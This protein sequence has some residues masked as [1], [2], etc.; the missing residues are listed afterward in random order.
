[1]KVSLLLPL[2]AALAHATV[3]PRVVKTPLERGT[4]LWA[5]LQD[6]KYPPFDL[7]I[8]EQLFEENYQVES[9]GEQETKLAS[10]L[11]LGGVVYKPPSDD[12]V[13]SIFT[14]VIQSNPPK[15]TE[16]HFVQQFVIEK[17]LIVVKDIDQ[18]R[19]K[20]PNTCRPLQ[21]DQITFR[22]YDRLAR[23]KGSPLSKLKWVAQ[24]HII[25]P[26]TLQ[27][28]KEVHREPGRDGWSKWTPTDE[29]PTSFLMILGTPNAHGSA[30]LL[31]D[32]RE[33]LGGP[34]RTIA[35]IRAREDNMIIEYNDAPNP[36]LESSTVEATGPLF[37]IAPELFSYSFVGQIRRIVGF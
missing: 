6:P 29:D 3:L 21:W 23:E 18:E 4:E 34:T 12:P 2:I 37:R 33:Y 26:E 24:M 30:N 28:L 25:N 8:L 35:S 1:M 15:G 36:H 14:R 27:V 19:N 5:K 22:E 17:G 16:P 20:N 7:P 31:L 11:E 32:F 10:A 9:E 13:P